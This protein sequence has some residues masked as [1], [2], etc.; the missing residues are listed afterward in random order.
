M[1]INIL[2]CLFAGL[3]SQAL[4]NTLGS[5]TGQFIGDTIDGKPVNI[6]SAIAGSIGGTFGPGIAKKLFGPVACE[7]I[8]CMALTVCFLSM[9]NQKTLPACILLHTLR[10]TLS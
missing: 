5:F 4:L 10:G 2:N 9:H 8:V 7:L 1:L 6:Q 3:A